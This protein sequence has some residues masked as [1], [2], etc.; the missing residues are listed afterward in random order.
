MSQL[1]MAFYKN[2]HFG[3]LVI[4]LRQ[5]FLHEKGSGGLAFNKFAAT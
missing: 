1:G 4:F 3:N 5:F 2:F